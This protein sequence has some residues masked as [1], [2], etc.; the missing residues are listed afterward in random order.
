MSQD[1]PFSDAMDETEDEQ[2]EA[3]D[4][5]V[6]LKSGFDVETFLENLADGQKT[7]TIGIAVSEEMHAVWRELRQDDTVEIDVAESIRN[8]LENLAHRHPKA[9]ERAGRKLEID[10]EL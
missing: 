6:A 8:H 1:N 3:A 4:D 2:Q 7:E 10:R 9:A 5:A